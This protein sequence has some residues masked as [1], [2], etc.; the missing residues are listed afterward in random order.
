MM[1]V[2]VP[3]GWKWLNNSCLFLLSIDC[4]SAS[5]VPALADSWPLASPA[6]R[7]SAARETDCSCADCGL[8]IDRARAMDGWL[9]ATTIEKNQIATPSALTSSTIKTILKKIQKR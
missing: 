4:K 5:A 3:T 7:E 2:A 6:V 8:V 9:Y 1:F